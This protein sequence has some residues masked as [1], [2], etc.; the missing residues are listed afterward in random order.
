M[1]LSADG[2]LASVTL[3]AF[4]AATLLPLSSE[5]V[6]FGVLRLHPDLYWP[7]II[8]ATAGNTAGGMTTYALGRWFAREKP[9]QRLDQAR[10]EVK[11][12]LRCGAP[13]TAL[14][15]VPLIGDTLCLAAGWLRLNM[16]AVLLWQLLGRFARYVAVAQASGFPQSGV[17]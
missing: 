13:A 12:L 5:A 7:A 8:A 16:T 1:L 17:L 10:P 6:L 4:I 11:R 2:G 14:G 9:L 15:W 3:S